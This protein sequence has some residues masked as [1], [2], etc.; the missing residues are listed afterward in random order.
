MYVHQWMTPGVADM[1]FLIARDCSSD[2]S[3]KKDARPACQFQQLSH[4]AKWCYCHRVFLAHPSLSLSFLS[5]SVAHSYH[6]NLNSIEF[7]IDK[8]RSRNQYRISASLDSI[9]VELDKRIRVDLIWNSILRWLIRKS[10]EEE[11]EEEGDKT[12]IKHCWNT[13]EQNKIPW[14]WLV[15]N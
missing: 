14:E 7:I 12:I 1:S 9:D 3:R 4:F 11:E 6:K 13:S 2:N 8:D 15:L 5:S 10:K